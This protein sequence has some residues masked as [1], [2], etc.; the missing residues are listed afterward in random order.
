MGTGKGRKEKWWLPFGRNKRPAEGRV[1]KKSFGLGVSL[2]DGYLNLKDC[3]SSFQQVID[4]GQSCWKKRNAPVA[5]A[6]P[7]SAMPGGNYQGESGPRHQLTK[8]EGRWNLNNKAL[9]MFGGNPEDLCNQLWILHGF[10]NCMLYGGVFAMQYSRGCTRDCQLGRL[11]V[12]DVDLRKAAQRPDAVY[13]MG[14][15]AVTWWETC[16]SQPSV[17]HP[18]AWSDKKVAHY[19]YTASKTLCLNLV[20]RVEVLRMQT[21]GEE[22][23]KGSQDAISPVGV[24]PGVGFWLLAFQRGWCVRLKDQVHFIFVSVP[25]WLQA[26]GSGGALRSS[27]CALKAFKF[28]LQ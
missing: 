1:Q 6:W 8:K 9:P 12:H 13:V 7:G 2:G 15:A 28:S 4:A 27:F 11:C 14:A 25:F 24:A 19:W 20:L 18:G 26:W 16:G 21:E 5:E 23:Q 22:G 17:I 10:G 3:I